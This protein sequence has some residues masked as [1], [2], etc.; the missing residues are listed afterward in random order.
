MASKDDFRADL[1]EDRTRTRSSSL[2]STSS[3]SS[4]KRRMP[5]L[6]LEYGARHVA[7]GASE[8]LENIAVS[9]M[10]PRL[11]LQNSDKPLV[12]RG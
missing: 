12:I 4:N 6:A 11:R 3:A 2:A 5:F 1:K 8:V 9:V 10:K 7:V